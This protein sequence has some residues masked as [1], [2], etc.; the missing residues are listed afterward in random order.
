MLKSV[1][2]KEGNMKKIDL[3]RLLQ[4]HEEVAEEAHRR[5][6]AA[7][8]SSERAIAAGKALKKRLK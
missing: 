1:V 8:E 6:S 4:R 7:R 5:A 3:Q 2:R